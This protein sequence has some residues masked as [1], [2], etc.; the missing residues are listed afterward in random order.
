MFVRNAG[1]GISTKW[2]T[3]PNGGW[4][5]WADMGGA[6]IQEAPAAFT[7]QG[8]RIELFA[9]APRNDTASVLHWYQPA[10][11][12]AFSGVTSLPIAP[13]SAPTVAMDRDG[14]LELL[15]R[16]LDVKDPMVQTSGNSYTMSLWQTSPGGGWATAAGALG[17]RPDKGGIG[18]PAAVTAGDQRIVA[19]VRNRG[20][21]ISMNRRSSVNGVFGDDWVDL[22]GPGAGQI[23]G[24]PAASVDH[25][26]L[27]DLVALGLDGRMYDNRQ[28][29]DGSF[30]K[31]NW[32]PMG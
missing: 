20:G 1:G 12:Q 31:Y 3:A 17:G 29:P 4:S 30:S 6:G 23:V 27:A 25:N 2:Q 10:I 22:A 16:Q 14:R 11:N 8:G 19:F 5:G 32:K 24:V 21:G 15:Y 26:G 13:T 18:A 7:T 9:W 28:N